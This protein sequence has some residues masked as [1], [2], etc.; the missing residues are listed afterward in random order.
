MFSYDI[1]DG[2]EE[3]KNFIAEYEEEEKKEENFEKSL[4][5]FGFSSSFRSAEDPGFFY[6]EVFTKDGYQND[7]IRTAPFDFIISVDLNN[8]CEN[9]A[10][11]NFPSLVELLSKISATSGVINHL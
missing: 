9:I 11:T 8:R 7:N 5:D 10:V 3:I 2:W 6:I 1:N 4:E